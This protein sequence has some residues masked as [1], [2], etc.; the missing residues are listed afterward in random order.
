M[1]KINFSI[2]FKDGSKVSQK[3]EFG[4]DAKSDF[5]YGFSQGFKN[6]ADI[7]IN[8]NITKKFNDIKSVTISFDWLK[9]EL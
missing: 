8:D 5:F 6:N 1:S 2:T 3:S 4:H 7:N 9:R